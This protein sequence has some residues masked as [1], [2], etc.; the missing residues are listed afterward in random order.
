MWPDSRSDGRCGLA[1]GEHARHR[2]GGYGDDAARPGAARQTGNQRRSAAGWPA[3]AGP[4]YRRPGH[5][6]P[7][8]AR[9]YDNRAECYREAHALL[10]T[11]TESRF[12]GYWT[13]HYGKLDRNLDLAPKPADG[14]LP[15]L[16][17]D[18]CGKD[19]E[20]MAGSCIK[21]ISQDSRTC[22]LNG[23]PA[24]T[25]RCSSPTATGGSSASMSPRRAAASR[26]SPPRGQECADRLAEATRGARRVAEV[27]EELAEYVLP[28][29]PVGAVG[30]SGK[31]PVSSCRPVGGRGRATRWRGHSR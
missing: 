6:I 18:C 7:S 4:V 28:K 24:A 1:S 15:V 23:G 25:G 20:W 14:R 31:E 19:I 5:R 17:I 3:V 26:P 30:I 29:F 2:H 10:R 9:C 22:W 11:I 8:V 27:L 12:P 16:A 13:E 21:A